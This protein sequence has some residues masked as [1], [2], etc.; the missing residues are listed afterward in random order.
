MRNA[1]NTNKAFLML[2]FASSVMEFAVSSGRLIFSFFATNFSTFVIW[3]ERRQSNNLKISLPSRISSS[4]LRHLV[5]RL[6]P[7]AFDFG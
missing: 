6:E 7:A 4:P 5:P 1:S 3:E 2:P